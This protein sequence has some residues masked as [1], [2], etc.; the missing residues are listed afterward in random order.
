MRANR[1]SIIYGVIS[2]VVV[3]AVAAGAAALFTT[4]SKK[5]SPTVFS[6]GGIH[7]DGKHVA[8]KTSIYTKDFLECQGLT[9]EPDFE[10]KGTFQVFY[11][12]DDKSFLGATNTM[13]A[14]DGV[15]SK[16]DTFPL[17][18]YCRIMITPEIEI[19]EEDEDA[20]LEIK[21]WQ[22][23]GYANDYIVR[24][25]RDQ[26]PMYRLSEFDYETAEKGYKWSYTEASESIERV[27][28]AASSIFTS[29]NVKGEDMM[30]IVFEDEYS[31]MDFTLLFE[32]K[33]GT[34]T[35]IDPD[36]S[37]LTTL[38]GAAVLENIVIPEG[39]VK[40]YVTVSGSLSE[41]NFYFK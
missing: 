17:A 12:D 24:V 37:R 32:L 35:T 23:T 20:T 16:L 38:Y 29:F 21:F 10:A 7:N 9:I 4:E 15:Y 8:V 19:D 26:T 1:K 22:V 34:T 2:L 28:D 5:I 41:F 31:A 13:N 6:V 40:C 14:T 11:Y 33:D 27:T 39:A 3:I 18:T 30:V 36:E 25:Y